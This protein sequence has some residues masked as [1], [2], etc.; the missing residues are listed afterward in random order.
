MLASP[1]SVNGFA[2]P[3][4]GDW[5]E[6]CARFWTG[7]QFRLAS[8]APCVA[9]PAG[10]SAL[11]TMGFTVCLIVQALLLTLFLR[12][13]LLGSVLG[14]MVLSA[15]LALLPLDVA[16]LADCTIAVR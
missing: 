15:L 2:R 16:M 1:V 4:R 3:K 13:H 7:N 12:Q 14:D 8:P 9:L 6:H 10:F 5:R 11:V